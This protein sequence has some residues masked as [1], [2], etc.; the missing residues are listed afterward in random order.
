M[1]KERVWEYIKRY[2]HVSFAELKREF[3][4]FDGN[5][6]KAIREHNIILWSGISL[7]MIEAI[8]SLIKEKLIDIYPTTPL[9]YMADGAVL[10]LP[11]AKSM[12]KYKK[13]HWA[14]VVFNVV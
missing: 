5:Y 8:D 1:L 14:P 10:S 11:I 6:E 2:N 12:R 13:P 3:P 7:E 4:E 9:V